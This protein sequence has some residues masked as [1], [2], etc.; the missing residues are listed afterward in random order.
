MLSAHPL[1]PPHHPLYPLHLAALTIQS[2]VRRWLARRR[3]AHA[4]ARYAVADASLALRSR[5]AALDQRMHVRLARLDARAARSASA[6]ASALPLLRVDAERLAAVASPWPARSPWDAP[7]SA[8]DLRAVNGSPVG[9]RLRVLR[10]MYSAQAGLDAKHAPLSRSGTST[11]MQRTAAE[12]AARIGREARAWDESGR[13]VRMGAQRV[14]HGL[15]V[16]QGHLARVAE[17]VVEMEATSEAMYSLSS[18]SSL[19]P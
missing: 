13:D 15:A 8:S 11:V 19:Q 3:A 10:R 1:P 17:A 14:V 16:V 4:A 7:A 18:S 5:I 9:D 2:A 6:G 12:L